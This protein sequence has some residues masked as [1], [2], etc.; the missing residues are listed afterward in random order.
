MWVTLAK[1]QGTHYVIILKLWLIFYVVVIFETELVK[2]RGEYKLENTNTWTSRLLAGSVAE[3]EVLNNS[4][5]KVLNNVVVECFW[6]QWLLCNTSDI[7]FSQQNIQWRP[8]YSV[9]YSWIELAY[10]NPKPK[11]Q[12]MF[13]NLL[14]LFK[15]FIQH[16]VKL[17]W[18]KVVSFLP[19]I[20][21]KGSF[22]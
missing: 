14:K 1:F 2:L 7:V 18:T 19:I 3:Q 11:G 21:H 9:T 4:S 20:S 17:K 8:H 22:L 15:T 12:E 6:R 10:T 16:F 13:N 5:T